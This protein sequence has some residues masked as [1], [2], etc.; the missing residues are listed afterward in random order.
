MDTK[1]NKFVNVT[2]KLSD[3]LN[4]VV[5]H[6]C[7]TTMAGMTFVVLLGVVF[8]YLLQMPL[9]WTEELSRYLMIWSASLAISIGIKEKGHVGLTVLVDRAKSKILRTIL[10]T[11]IFF[12]T[13]VFLSIMIYYSIQM[14]AEAKWQ[15][16]QG[17]GISMV[18]PTL[19][20]PVAMII[21]IVQLIAR[22]IL[23]LGKS[24]PADFEREIID[25]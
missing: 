12:V 6:L 15:I 1:D 23:D 14:V 25:I 22:Y 20:V 21:G 5:T 10:E 24:G 9:S 16:S 19:A 8:R 17:L 13:L 7:M 3:S 11:A 4:R 2:A 18:L